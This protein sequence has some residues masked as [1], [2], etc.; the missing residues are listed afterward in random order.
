MTGIT[1]I[2]AH[3]LDYAIGRAGSIPWHYPEDFAHFKRE[4]FGGTLIMGRKTFES[5]GRAL[6]NRRTV[7]LTRQ[8]AWTAEG[9]ETVLNLDEAFSLT[10]DDEHVFG[11]GG[12][13]VYREL[14]PLASHQILTVIPTVVPG[15]DAH[16]PVYEEI[17]WE[18]ERDFISEAGLRYR[19]LARR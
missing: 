14:F 19:W 9:V 8:A 11:A 6:P 12:E 1:L 10:R 16:Y 13:Q 2:A 7:V 3:G 5:I 18:T 17:K 15:A 4:T